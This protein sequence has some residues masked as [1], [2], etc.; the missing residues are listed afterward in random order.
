MYND[1]LQPSVPQANHDELT[2]ERLLPKHLDLMWEKVKHSDGGA[3]GLWSQFKTMCEVAKE[4][5]N[6]EGYVA[7][8][9]TN[10][11]AG[12][13]VVHDEH[14]WWVLEVWPIA[15]H[16]VATRLIRHVEEVAKAA[17]VNWLLVLVAGDDD[18]SA[19]NMLTECGYGHSDD[20]DLEDF[21]SSD[22]W[23]Y[24]DDPWLLVPKKLAET[25]GHIES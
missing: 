11:I 2:V 15:N 5:S 25:E 7:T 16:A 6:G 3:L 18:D 21:D 20:S 12:A 1:S 24:E 17:K 4:G 8:T 13:V 10:E 23:P 14:D 9:S 19:L 22:F